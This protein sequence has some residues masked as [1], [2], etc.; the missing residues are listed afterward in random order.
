[1]KGFFICD[2]LFW[3]ETCY[4]FVYTIDRVTEFIF[5]AQFN[6]RK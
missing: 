3:K 5:V 2:D 6:M 4:Y 1:M